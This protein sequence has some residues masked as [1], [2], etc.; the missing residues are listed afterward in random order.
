ML[1]GI[2]PNSEGVE[3]CVVF[4]V[5]NKP[6]CAWVSEREVEGSKIDCFLFAPESALVLTLSPPKR[7][8]DE[9]PPVP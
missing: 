1:A 9:G 7:P 2:L 4:V 8:P 6:G 3:A 5:E